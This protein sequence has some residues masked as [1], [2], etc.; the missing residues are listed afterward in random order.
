MLKELYPIFNPADEA[1]VWYEGR[2]ICSHCIA[3]QLLQWERDK[4]S[5]G[6]DDRPQ[7]AVTLDNHWV[8]VHCDYF[9][10]RVENPEQLQFCAAIRHPDPERTQ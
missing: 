5:I 10:R 4:S 6:A 7:H 9:K 2:T 3:G 8:A 1:R